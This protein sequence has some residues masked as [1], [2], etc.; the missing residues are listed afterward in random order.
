MSCADG[1]TLGCR[2]LFF[3]LISSMGFY[4]LIMAIVGVVVVVA[5][6]VVDFFFF[7]YRV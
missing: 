2:F 5:A 3:D 4:F 7:G 1:I 6:Y